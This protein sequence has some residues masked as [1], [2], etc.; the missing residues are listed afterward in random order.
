MI[1]DYLHKNAIPIVTLLIAVFILADGQCSKKKEKAFNDREAVAVNEITIPHDQIELL[2]SG[3]AEAVKS[4]IADCLKTIP[5]KTEKIIIH[6]NH[7]RDS[8]K[9]IIKLIETIPMSGK[10]PIVYD[11]RDGCWGFKGIF[12][13]TDKTFSLW[14]RTFD[15]QEIVGLA[16]EPKKFLGIRLRIRQFAPFGKEYYKESF[17]QCTQEVNRVEINLR[18]K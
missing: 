5:V 9:E 12:N 17:N 15:N 16:W 3:L 4:I 14:D 18:K 10:F 6:N 13:S 8:T 1:K 7:Y 2:E 11:S